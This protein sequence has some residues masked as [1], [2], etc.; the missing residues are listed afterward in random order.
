VSSRPGSE[1]A[2]SVLKEAI[3]RAHNGTSFI[4]PAHSQRGNSIEKR[5]QHTKR[6]S[7]ERAGNFF[8]FYYIL[9]AVGWLA[10]S[11]AKGCC[12]FISNL[13]LIYNA[14]DTS[15]C[16]QG[17]AAFGAIADASAPL[18]PPVTHRRLRFGAARPP[19]AP[20]A[21]D[22]HDLPGHWVAVVTG[23]FRDLSATALRFLF[24]SPSLFT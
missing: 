16:A 19:V 7:S 18:A 17:S 20:P 11:A 8:S 21:T 3:T 24:S 15:R 13:F 6:R 4:Y 22:S 5:L 23:A 14:P 9:P 10:G 1:R 2:A 12:L